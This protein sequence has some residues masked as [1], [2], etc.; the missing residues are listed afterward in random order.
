MFIKFSPR[1][2]GGLL[3]FCLALVRWTDPQNL[4]EIFCVKSLIAMANAVLPKVCGSIGF[5]QVTLENILAVVGWPLG[6]VMGVPAQDCW[7]VGK[8]I[9]VKTVL[10]E[11]V[12]Y[13]QMA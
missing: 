4:K 1:R 10:N 5:P 12:A 13:L 11:F 7:V 3:A 9:G 6:W 8:L 2:G